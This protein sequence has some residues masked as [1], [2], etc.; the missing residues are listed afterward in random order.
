MNSATYQYT[1]TIRRQDGTV[2]AT[3]ALYQLVNAYEPGV[4]Q[5]SPHATLQLSSQSLFTQARRAMELDA[6]EQLA[7]KSPGE[8]RLRKGDR[9]ETTGLGKTAKWPPCKGT[10]ERREGK[11]VYIQWDNSFVADQMEE[12]ELRLLTGEDP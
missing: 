6:L 8:R 7:A 2:V 5:K 12:H 1:L 3:D 4:V 11:D 9:A 10:V